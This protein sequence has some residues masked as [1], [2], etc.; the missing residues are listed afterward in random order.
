MKKKRYWHVAMGVLWEAWVWMKSRWKF[1][2][3]GAVLSVVVA[4]LLARWCF[5]SPLSGEEAPIHMTGEEHHKHHKRAEQEDE[6]GMLASIFP[7]W[8]SETDHEGGAGASSSAG[9]RKLHHGGVLELRGPDDLEDEL[10]RVEHDGGGAH[11]WRNPVRRK[12]ASEIDAVAL[13]AE[14]EAVIHRN[15]AAREHPV[16]T[17]SEVVAWIRSEM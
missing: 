9:D 5:S 15:R 6:P 7:S 2:L 3:V 12:S 17:A 13:E 11:S 14:L 16:E 10:D 8:S 1:C 4:Y